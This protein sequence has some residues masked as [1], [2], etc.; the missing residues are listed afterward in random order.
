MYKNKKTG[1][2]LPSLNGAGQMAPLLAEVCTSGDFFD[3][4]LAIDSCS[5]DE[6]VAM[7]YNA[8]FMVN[9][10]EKSVFSHGRVRKIGMEKLDD[11]DYVV[12]VTQDVQPASGAFRT[13]VAFLD[14]HEQMVSAYGRQLVDLKQGNLLEA[15]SRMFNYPD[16][17]LVKSEA[18]IP[19][20]GIKTIFQSNAFA[21]Y[22]RNLVMEL[23]N[24][25]DDTNFA[26]DQ[27]LAAQAILNGYQ[28]GY[29]ADA[30]VY[31]QHNYTLYQEYKRFRNAGRFNKQYA[32]LLARFGSNEK[33]GMKYVMSELKYYA[34]HGHLLLVPKFMAINAA[35]FLGYKTG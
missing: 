34:T 4:K 1:L 9:T 17:S 29:C 15:R 2:F 28:V 31:H 8:G 24:F 26:E 7:L 19:E 13:L 11:V 25:P 18:S 5:T 32:D 35:K 27:Y 14:E 23:G 33:E 22:R 3:V 12:M 21:V 20:L 6:T 16:K 10:I 30:V